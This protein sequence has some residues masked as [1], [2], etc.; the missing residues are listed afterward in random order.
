LNSASIILVPNI[1]NM[2]H[3]WFFLFLFPLSLKAQDCKLKRTADPY[4]KEIQLS[5]GFIQLDGASLAI[6][7][8]PTEIDF[9]FS[10]DG[11]EKC[12]GDGSAVTVIYDGKKQKAN[13]KNAGPVNCDGIFHITFKNMAT[14]LTLLQRLITQKIITLQFTG[15]NKSQ[16]NINLSEDQQQAIMTK[17][18]CLIKE[19]KT[20]IK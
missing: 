7:A 18:D 9:F 3:Y 5:T 12:F 8:S 20:L 11:K 10:M 6:N 14:T 13:Y 16:I 19:A 4:T 2:R 1:S 15:N 17:G